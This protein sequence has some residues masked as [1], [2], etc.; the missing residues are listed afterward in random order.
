LDHRER[1]LTDIACGLA[2]LAERLL[3]LAGHDDARPD[4]RWLAG[5]KAELDALIRSVE[6]G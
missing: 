3:V 6:N 4:E 1:E 5:A 2:D